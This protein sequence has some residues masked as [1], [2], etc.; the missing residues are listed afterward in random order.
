[1]S[2]RYRPSLVRCPRQHDKS[3]V[4]V[5]PRSGLGPDR[6]APPPAT[7]PPRVTAAESGLGS[8]GLGRTAGAPRTSSRCWLLWREGSYNVLDSL[9]Q[10]QMPG[11]RGVNVAGP[12][13]KLDKQSRRA[14]R[15]PEGRRRTFEGGEAVGNLPAEGRGD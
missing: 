13:G 7:Y 4:V 12:V 8:R 10:Q 6:E 5:G 2:H 11:R 15:A 9:G 14:R 3:T 1:M